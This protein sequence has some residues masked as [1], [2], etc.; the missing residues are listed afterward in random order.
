MNEMN[1][2]NEMNGFHNLISLLFFLRNR[3]YNSCTYQYRHYHNEVLGAFLF[4]IGLL[5]IS[6]FRLA[7]FTGKAGLL[8]TK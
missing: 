1:D 4:S 6:H 2:L 7:L 5:T 3:D 8:A